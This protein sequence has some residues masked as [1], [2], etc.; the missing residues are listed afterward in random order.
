MPFPSVPK[1]T[2]SERTDIHSIFLYLERLRALSFDEVQTIINNSS[3]IVTVQIGDILVDSAT[4][5]FSFIASP[6]SLTGVVK[7]D[8]ITTVKLANAGVTYSKIQAI[9]ANRLLGKV[10][11]PGTV[12]ELTLN[13]DLEFSG[14]AIRLVAFTGDVTKTAGGTILT[15]PND[16]I[17]YA[18][19]QNIS[20]ASRLLGRGSASGS[21]DTQEL[22]TGVGLEIATT[23]L[24]T[25]IQLS[26]V[27]TQ[28][29]K[30]DTT[31]ANVSGLT[32][33]LV[34]SGVYYFKALLFVDASVV[35]G[36]KYTM[37]GTATA[38][39]IIYEITLLDNTTNVYTITARQ[40]ALAASSGQAGTT[41]GLAVV[42]GTI[43]VN[44]AGTLTVQFAQNVANGT[45]SVLVNSIFR[46][47]KIG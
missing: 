2:S 12:Q 30:T 5:D 47:E 16:T 35:G 38:T 46:V 8:S 31:L 1:E 15:I 25:T 6:A 13:S 42:E 21:G 32:A 11:S 22:T 4:I 28:F 10:T 14:T 33:T 39:S 17:T 9:A 24:Q 3:G 20:A 27:S 34:A 44:A 45:S 18:K 23:V 37:A 43:V 29:D 36:S 41:A 19:M 26:R 40:T 7:D